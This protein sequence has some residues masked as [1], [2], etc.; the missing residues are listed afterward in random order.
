VS[1]YVSLPDAATRGIDIDRREENYWK[2]P[3][4]STNK[5][6]RLMV[7]RV[8]ITSDLGDNFLPK[9]AGWIRVIVDGKRGSF[10]RIWPHRS[11]QDLS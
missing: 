4:V 6:F 11:H 1:A 9:W 7:K 3:A 8:F 5:H 2:D 10:P